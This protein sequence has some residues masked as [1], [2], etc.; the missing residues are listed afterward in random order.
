MALYD[1]TCTNCGTKTEKSKTIAERDDV[2]HDVC[3]SCGTIGSLKRGLAAPVIG[4]SI[5]TSGYGR[6]DNGFKEVL[7]QIHAETPGSRLKET[8]SHLF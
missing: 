6:I 4:Y 8:S 5:A 7:Q 3:P 2:E 1:Y